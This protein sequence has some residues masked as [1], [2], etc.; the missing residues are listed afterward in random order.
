MDPTHSLFKPVWIPRYIPVD[1][2]ATELQVYTFAS[3][4]CRYEYLSF[5]F[6]K[7][8]LRFSS[9]INTLRAMYGRYLVTCIFKLV[10]QIKQGVF[11]LS[12]ND[13]FFPGNNP[14][15]VEELTQLSEFL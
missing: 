5:R 10:F 4:I 6:E 3:S 1:K 12:E 15:R 9:F 2:E 13:Q 8:P 7:I 14:L 11:V